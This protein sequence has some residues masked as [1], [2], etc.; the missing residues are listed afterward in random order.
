MNMSRAVKRAAAALVGGLLIASTATTAHAVASGAQATGGTKIRSEYRMLWMD[1]EGASFAD[2]ARVIQWG[3]DDS[4]PNQRFDFVADSDGTYAI[5]ARHSGKCLDVFDA[6]QA[7]GAGL[8]QWPCNGDTNQK[9]RLESVSGGG[10]QLRAVHSGKCLEASWNGS[11]GQQ[12]RQYSCNGA[13][14]QRWTLW[15]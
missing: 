11:W 4:L 8:I 7:D 5:V 13:V 14:N 3:S 9:W 15:S 1:V 12:V 10:L 6:S 2:G